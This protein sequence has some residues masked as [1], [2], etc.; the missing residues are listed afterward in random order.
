MPEPTKGTG[1]STSSFQR[2]SSLLQLLLWSQLG[3]A[4][5]AL[6]SAVA[7]SRVHAGV[8]PF[9]AKR[10]SEKTK[11]HR[12]R[13]WGQREERGGAKICRSGG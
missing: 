4:S 5:A 13:R 12:R 8:A 9:F 11:E 7:G 2:P 6:L 10:E 3:R 1:I